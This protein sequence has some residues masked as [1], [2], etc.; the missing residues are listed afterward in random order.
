MRNGDLPAP[1]FRVQF[2]SGASLLP[3]ECGQRSRVGLTVCR[4]SRKRAVH[5]SWRLS[6]F[7]CSWSRS[8]PRSSR[9]PCRQRRLHSDGDDRLSRASQGG[10]VHS[11]SPHRDG[12][13]RAGRRYRPCLPCLGQAGSGGALPRCRAGDAGRADVPGPAHHQPGRAAAAALLP[14]RDS[15]D[16]PSGRSRSAAGDPNWASWRTA[17]RRMS[18]LS[19]TRNVPA[20]RG[21]RHRCALTLRPWPVTLAR[22]CWRH[23]I[24]A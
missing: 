11:A 14:R 7:R 19:R 15:D 2:L 24:H 6:W 23:H 5:V 16:G 3:L 21:C 22:H 18:P 17:S 8:R 12:G 4:G 13:R 9:P 20:L 1:W 10:A